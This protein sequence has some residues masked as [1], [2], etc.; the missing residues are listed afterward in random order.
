MVDHLKNI[1]IAFIGAGRRMQTVYLPV[2]RA[3]GIRIAGF[4]RRHEEKGREFERESGIRYYQTID[5][6]AKRDRPD[7]LL[8]SVP[9][10]AAPHTVRSALGTGIPLLIETPIALSLRDG[11]SLVSEARRS[12]RPVGVLEQK[13]F[14]PWEEMKALLIA[15]GVFGKIICAQNDFRSY[16]YHAIAQLRAYIGRAHRPVSASAVRRVAALPRYEH[17]TDA[18]KHGPREE[19]WNI[20][21]VAFDNGALLLHAMTSAYKAAPFRTFQSLRFYGERGSMI[22]ESAMV[23]G[24]AGKTRELVFDMERGVIGQTLRIRTVLPEGK[25]IAWQNPFPDALLT[26]DQVAIGRHFIAMAEAV[27]GHGAPLYGI[28]DALTDLAVVEAFRASACRNGLPSA[29][30][31]AALPFFHPRWWKEALQKIII[32]VW[33][34]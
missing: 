23:L 32:R 11:Q 31:R 33:K 3:L 5:E 21:T 24:G 19:T 8:V 17:K 25:E 16:D 12:G 34:K 4:T 18:D 22:N 26:D 13:P 6:L 28:E 29:V 27:R 15:S 1:S 9:P 20:G 30:G 14:L 10:K 7:I 2:V